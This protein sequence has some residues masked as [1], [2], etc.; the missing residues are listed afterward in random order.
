LRGGVT[1]L[2]PKT[3][4]SN[5]DQGNGWSH[6]TTLVTTGIPGDSGSGLLDSS[7]KATGVLST[8]G[9]SIPDGSTNN[10]GDLSRELDYLHAHT[11]FTAVQ[12][13][14]GTEPFNSGQLP[15]G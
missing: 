4:I 1:Q 14:N 8:V 11:S 15:L 9:V 10:F 12:L 6:G 5:G 13:V 7:G 3:G 2:S